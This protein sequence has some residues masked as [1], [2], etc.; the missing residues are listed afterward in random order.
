MDRSLMKI[1]GPVEIDRYNLCAEARGLD[2]GIAKRRIM[3]ALI[4]QT[5]FFHSFYDL[6]ENLIP[7]LHDIRNIYPGGLEHSV[8]WRYRLDAAKNGFLHGESIDEYVEQ[9]I[10]EATDKGSLNVQYYRG[11]PLP[12]GYKPYRDRLSFNPDSSGGVYLAA[13]IIDTSNLWKYSVLSNESSNTWL[14][15]K[16]VYAIAKIKGA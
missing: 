10:A 12:D 4:V 13:A 9:L 14:H 11:R 1:E 5:P 6:I 3:Y 15:G 16:R 8:Q 2:F 7:D